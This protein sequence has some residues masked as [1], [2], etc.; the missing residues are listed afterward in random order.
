MLIL[1]VLN[2]FADELIIF[3]NSK[4]NLKRINKYCSLHGS[5][6]QEVGLFQQFSKTLD[7]VEKEMRMKEEEVEVLRIERQQLLEQ[8]KMMVDDKKRITEEIQK[9]N[10]SLKTECSKNEK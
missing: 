2:L 4:S 6:S 7:G 3:I 8:T 10:D 1:T 5:L 9:L